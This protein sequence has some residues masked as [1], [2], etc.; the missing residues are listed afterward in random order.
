MSARLIEALEKALG[1]II[2]NP[3]PDASVMVQFAA[4]DFTKL[5]DAL[6]QYKAELSAAQKHDIA[7]AAGTVSHT[8]TGQPIDPDTRLSMAASEM[9]AVSTPYVAPADPPP[10]PVTEQQMPGDPPPDELP[11]IEGASI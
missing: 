9:E 5:R 6:E 10:D 3:G 2:R 4:G 1:Q 7:D 11:P 8:P